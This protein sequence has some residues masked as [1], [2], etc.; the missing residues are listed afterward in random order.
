MGSIWLAPLTFRP[1]QS[2]TPAHQFPARKLEER[3]H[4]LVLDIDETLVHSMALSNDLY[5]TALRPY[6]IPFL[7]EMN[8]LFEVIF[9]TAGTEFYGNAVLQAIEE[10]GIA[11]DGEPVVGSNP[12]ALYRQHTSEDWNYMKYI[13]MLRRP[14]QNVL[15]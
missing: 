3:R 2:E 15:M 12:T 7:R 10:A 6:V 8:E 11:Y 14:V 1:G 5:I 13:P 9:W 4:T